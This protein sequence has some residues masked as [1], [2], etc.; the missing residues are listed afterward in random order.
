MRDLIINSSVQYTL[1]L[2]VPF[3]IAVIL[4]WS[5]IRAW[6]MVG[7]LVGGILLGPMILGSVAPTYWDGVFQ[8][9]VEEHEEVFQLQRQQQAD[10]LAATTLGVDQDLLL[11]MRADQQY[12]QSTLQERWEDSKW[13]DQR[14]LRIFAISLVVFILLSGSDRRAKRKT[15]SDSNDSDD[16]PLL[17]SL[18]VGAWSS[19]VPGG[20]VA[21][22]S[23]LFWDAPIIASLAIGAC[24]G[25]GPWTLSRWEQ[26]TADGSE[27]GGALLMVRCGRVAWCV[28]GIA[29]ITAVWQEHGAMALVWLLP[30]FLLPVIWVIPPRDGRLLRWFVDFAAIPSV[31]ATSLVLIDPVDAFQLWPVL[32]VIL[33]CADARWLGG[34]VGLGILGGR[35]SA[36][37]MRLSIPLVDAG[38]SQLCLVTLLFGAGVLTPPLAFAVIIGALFLEITAPIR[39]KFTT[40]TFPN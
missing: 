20:C 18:S 19:I 16:A 9:G 25:A 3:V 31:V 38:V 7:G 10:L 30:L 34:V 2:V 13:E 17:M 23:Y 36:E 27:T 14:T 40:V 24:L 12:E 37:A 15:Y 22:I 32:V 33:L 1:L 4:K 35:T 39:F 21:V 5:K 29:A 28:A 26:R 11:Q 6:S 8:G